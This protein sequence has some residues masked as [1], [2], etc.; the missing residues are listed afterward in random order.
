LITINRPDNGQKKKEKKAMK[1]SNNQRACEQWRRHVEGEHEGFLLMRRTD[2][3][4][5][6]VEGS[7]G[8][9]PRYL[10][11]GGG[12]NR[13]SH[14]LADFL[15]VTEGEVARLKGKGI[16]RQVLYVKRMEVWQYKEAGQ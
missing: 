14:A 12:Y 15:G 10:I 4:N 2:S 16:L 13:A 6:I 11:D 5:L 9:A 8:E 1:K 3:G 7:G